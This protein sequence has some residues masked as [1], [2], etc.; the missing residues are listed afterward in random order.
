M[1]FDEDITLSK[2]WDRN[3][4]LEF[5]TVEALR[6]VK[7]PLLGGGRCHCNREVEQLCTVYAIAV[8]I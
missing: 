6:S 5:E 8:M 4:L 1:K 7:G 2:L 3:S